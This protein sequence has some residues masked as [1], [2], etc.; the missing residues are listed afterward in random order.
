MENR[1]LRPSR[2][3]MVCITC[4]QFRHALTPIGTTTPACSRHE[5]LLPQ[6]SHLSHRCYQW[7]QRLES[8]TDWSPEAA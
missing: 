1:H 6:G 3:L 2:S 8:E 5:R 4:Q 7:M